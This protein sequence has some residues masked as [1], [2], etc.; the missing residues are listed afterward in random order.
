MPSGADT[1]QVGA[2]P[3]PPHEDALR[4]RTI[5]LAA[6]F[7][8]TQGGG[9]DKRGVPTP[10]VQFDLTEVEMKTRGMMQARVAYFVTPKT[11]P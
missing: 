2:S 5:S 4:G 7:L 10:T 3:L 8:L 1:E 9:A 6:V 11:L